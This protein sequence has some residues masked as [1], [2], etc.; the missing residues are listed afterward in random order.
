MFRKVYF[1]NEYEFKIFVDFLIDKFKK[2]NVERDI[3][4]LRKFLSDSFDLM[5]F[6]DE[7]LNGI[8][9]LFGNDLVEIYDQDRFVDY[10]FE[11][12]D[13]ESLMRN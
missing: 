9:V 13:V 3:E 6:C 4:K 2:E 5:V 1:L 7:N 8:V 12:F 11:K 10:V